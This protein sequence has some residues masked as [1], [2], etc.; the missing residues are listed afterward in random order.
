MKKNTLTMLALVSG[1]LMI[2]CAS[3]QAQSKTTRANISFDFAAANNAMK[4]G[5]YMVQQVGPQTILL[6]SF[7]RKSQA[8]VTTPQ[9]VNSLNRRPQRLVFRRYGDSYF[10]GEIWTTEFRGLRFAA[11]KEENAIAKSGERPQTIEI[12]L[13]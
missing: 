10:L 3:V 4:A 6:K 12:A 13:R 11:S 2:A 5:E 8:Y 7:D 9:G 1:I